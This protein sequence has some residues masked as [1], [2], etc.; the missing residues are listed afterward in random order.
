GPRDVP[1]PGPAREV[2]VIQCCVIGAWAFVDQLHFI[3]LKDEERAFRGT[4]EHGGGWRDRGASFLT[5]RGAAVEIDDL[6]Y[7]V[8]VGARSNLT[9]NLNPIFRGV[10]AFWTE[11]HQGGS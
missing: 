1:P 5:L 7:F 6:R 8:F 3:G 10:R 2:G 11:H 9:A 4:Q